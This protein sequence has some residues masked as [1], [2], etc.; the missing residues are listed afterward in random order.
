MTLQVDHVERVW[1][2]TI[3]TPTPKLTRVSLMSDFGTS[4]SSIDQSE[5]EEEE[6]GGGG[7][8]G[9]QEREVRFKERARIQGSEVGVVIKIICTCVC[10]GM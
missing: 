6:G 2:P 3:A 10:I 5:R 1:S 4:C 9:G 8:G 7:G